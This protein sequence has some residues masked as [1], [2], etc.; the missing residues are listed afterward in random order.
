MATEMIT[1][2]LETKFLKSIDNIVRKEGYQS[3]TEFIRNALRQKIEE[4]K[5]REFMSEMHKIK[6]ASK[7]KISDEDYEIV[8]EK[9]FEELSRKFR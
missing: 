5:L 4:E 8:R 3:R 7:K 2:K 9:A 6:G 1:L